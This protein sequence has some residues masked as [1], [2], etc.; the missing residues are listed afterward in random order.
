[1]V[2]EEPGRMALDLLRSIVTM[3]RRKASLIYG[4][5]FSASAGA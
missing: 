5:A 1:M 3:R 2:V 4:S